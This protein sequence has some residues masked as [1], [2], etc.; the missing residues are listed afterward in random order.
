MG[1]C[2]MGGRGVASRQLRRRT[3]VASTVLQAAVRLDGF[4]GEGRNGYGK[5]EKKEK[6]KKRKGKWVWSCDNQSWGERVGRK[7]ER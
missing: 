5:E 3:A 4:L 1:K 6:K 2:E 7:M